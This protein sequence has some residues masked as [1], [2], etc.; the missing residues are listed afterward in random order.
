MRVDAPTLVFLSQTTSDHV[1][2]LARA[3]WWFFAFLALIGG[4]G[5]VAKAWS[6]F[7]EVLRDRRERARRAEAE[8]RARRDAKNK[9]E[10]KASEAL[11]EQAEALANMARSMP[12]QFQNVTSELREANQ[13]M[14][15]EL[16][17]NTRAINGFA[18]AWNDEKRVLLAAI[19]NKLGVQT[20]DEPSLR[21]VSSPG[22]SSLSPL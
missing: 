1:D 13:L 3:P 19:A 8:E 16:A 2:G 11:A 6:Y 12:Q 14:R 10:I 9:A 7:G 21:R 4:T 5:G 15:A 17:E 22:Q 20:T 18:A